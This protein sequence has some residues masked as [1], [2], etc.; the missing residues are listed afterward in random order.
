MK[1]QV[2]ID[3]Q[4]HTY[5]ECLYEGAFDQTS[6]TRSSWNAKFVLVLSLLE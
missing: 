1:V 5:T 3:T 2:E 6:P 4:D